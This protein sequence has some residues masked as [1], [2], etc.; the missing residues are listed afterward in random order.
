[1]N[2][3]QKLVVIRADASPT[4]GG[5]HI[6]R[7][8]ALAE[9]FEQVGL[10]WR[11]A[12][13]F[14]PGTLHTV[15]DLQA[16]TFECLEIDGPA[17]DEPAKMSESWPVG[18]DL[19]VIDHYALDAAF[20]AACRP[21]AR[22]MLVIDDLANRTHQSDFLLDQSNVR[23]EDDY[24]ALV[25]PA[26][27]LLLGSRY[28]LL[29]RE[30][31]E[32]RDQALAHRRQ[33]G[34]IRRVMVSMGA[35]D[36]HDL[37]SMALEA[38][39]KTGVDLAVDVVM[40]KNAHNLGMVRERL[41]GFPLPATIM[42]EA[43]NMAKLMTE[44]DVAI[45]AFGMTSLERCCLGLPTLAVVTA[46][47][48]NANADGLSRA[49]AVVNLGGHSDLTVEAL[50]AQFRALCDDPERR[51]SLSERAAGICDGLGARRVAAAVAG[52]PHAHIGERML[53]S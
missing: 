6:G 34:G 12:F 32:Y 29:R 8:W 33:S 24:R 30:F 19:L 35:I 52:T 44:A 28:A 31:A 23:Q 40:G 7:C 27:T 39:E 5:G 48:Q 4:I 20:E 21:W 3:G 43:P 49:G 9:A 2:E 47:N 26:C 53:V 13:V 10:Q 45:G 36:P 41:A 38:I 46:E 37:T 15:A 25:G 17:D 14:R 42:V 50:T 16:T 22:S 51:L 18:C 11:I 1:M